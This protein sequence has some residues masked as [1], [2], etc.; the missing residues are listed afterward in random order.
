MDVMKE[1]RQVPAAVE[2]VG[3]EGQ[4]EGQLAD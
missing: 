4:S 2:S 3:K 1:Y